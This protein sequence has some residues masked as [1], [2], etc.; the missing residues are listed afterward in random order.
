MQWATDPESALISIVILVCVF[1]RHAILSVDAAVRLRTY[2]SATSWVVLT[3]PDKAGWSLNISCYVYHLNLD[4]GTGTQQQNQTIPAPQC[5]AARSFPP[6]RGPLPPKA[7]RRMAQPRPHRKQPLQPKRHGGCKFEGCRGSL[8]FAVWFLRCRGAHGCAC[9][10]SVGAVCGTSQG[11]ELSDDAKK[12][13]AERAELGPKLFSFLQ[14]WGVSGRGSRVPNVAM[15]SYLCDPRPRWTQIIWQRPVW[16]TSLSEAGALQNAIEDTRLRGRFIW[17][18]AHLKLPQVVTAGTPSDP[19][20][21]HI[22][23]SRLLQ[24][25]QAWG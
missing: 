20:S 1:N 10:N 5:S 11:A 14:T 6:S 9:H 2:I 21:R 4:A 24:K 17:A 18:C 8:H 15:E 25:R 3:K 7:M 22:Q 23:A 16:C 12:N 13:L 19:W